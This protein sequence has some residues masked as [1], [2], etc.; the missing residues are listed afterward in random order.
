[1]AMTA[2]IWTINGLASELDRDRRTIGAALR[3]VN[4][5]GKTDRGHKGWYM[6]TA[7]KALGAG[8]RGGSSEDGLDKNAELA[9]KAKEEADKLEMENALR[10]G[11]LREA[12]DVDAAVIAA[13]T[14]VRSRLLAVP[15]KLAP[16]VVTA[17]DANA[18]EAE[19]SVAIREVLRELS[20]TNVAQL[21]ADDGDL[22]EGADA[23]A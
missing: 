22:V 19:I 6:E 15:S 8:G 13:F 11:E 4:H 9:R 23:A 1:M 3:D 21:E 10:R 7:L 2:R 17:E 18:A 16:K 14:R 12:A 20:E 5:D